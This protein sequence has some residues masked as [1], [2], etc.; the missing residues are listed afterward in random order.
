VVVKIL[1]VVVVRNPMILRKLLTM[2]SIRWRWM[3][4]KI[5][6]IMMTVTKTITITT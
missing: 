5:V 1:V 6:I 2:S 4:L 3:A